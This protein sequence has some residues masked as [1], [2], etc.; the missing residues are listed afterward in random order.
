MIFY[1]LFIFLTILFYFQNVQGS[2]V[3]S[4]IKAFP[5]KEVI[6]VGNACP[7]K[8]YG[9][10]V[11]IQNT[12]YNLLLDTRNIIT[13][14]NAKDC[15]HGCIPADQYKP[16]PNSILERSRI[17]GYYVDDNAWG[18][19]L[20][21]DKLIL[22][23]SIYVSYNLKFVSLKTQSKPI[24]NPVCDGSSFLTSG[25]V[26]LGYS[27]DQNSFLRQYATK[28]FIDKIYSIVLCENNPRL[29]FGGFDSSILTSPMALYNLTSKSFGLEITDTTTPFI[30]LPPS[31][32]QQTLQILGRS[33]PFTRYF[34]SRF[35]SEKK[36]ILNPFNN[37]TNDE[38]NAYL[39]PLR[40]SYRSTILG[41]EIVL[42]AT[43]SYL[44]FD[45][46]M[47]CPGIMETLE[48][49][50]IF[51]IP[52]FKE[53]LVM[54]DQENNKLGIGKATCKS[55][56]WVPSS[57]TKC[58]LTAIG[59]PIQKRTIQCQS[60]KGDILPEFRC[61]GLLKPPVTKDCIIRIKKTLKPTPKPTKRAL[62]D[63]DSL[64][65]SDSII[66]SSINET[67]TQPDPNTTP[68]VIRNLDSEI[69]IES[70][71][72][73]DSADF[74]DISRVKLSQC[75]EDSLTGTWKIV[76]NWSECDQICGTGAQTRKVY[77]IGKY[78]QKVKEAYC[79]AQKPPMKRICKQKKC[80]QDYV[81]YASAWSGCSNQCGGGTQSRQV[82]CVD[83]TIYKTV[84]N[85]QCLGPKPL[86]VRDCIGQPFCSKYKW[87]WKPCKP[88]CPEFTTISCYNMSTTEVVSDHYCQH[89]PNL[90]FPKACSCF[91]PPISSNETSNKLQEHSTEG[92]SSSSFSMPSRYYLD[93]KIITTMFLI[94]ILINILI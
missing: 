91:V 85:A 42:V 9:L 66:S 82:Y 69:D 44:I 86:P 50:T 92:S 62:G 18:G 52:L 77:C 7:Y 63:D 17:F 11:T 37:M 71:E 88:F 32:Y 80:V 2:Y 15:K 12:T 47:V 19:E 83:S 64:P 90:F 20:M 45:G 34:S 72:L 74:E 59:C 57:W 41:S 24:S 13:T 51:G 54:F 94:T 5:L 46:D 14:I 16:S 29:W 73:V 76:G 33:V 49:N 61:S 60:E 78:G 25:L 84:D 81:W 22:D 4:Q 87:D 65:S 70:E 28:N 89:L 56:A 35:F 67:S 21:S 68:P 53:Y 30:H 55:T 1:K 26:G 23:T 43:S 48:Y 93:E 39:P 38:I 58:A 36:C 40:F 8:S 3:T 27:N 10:P 75:A 79:T 6:S 31:L